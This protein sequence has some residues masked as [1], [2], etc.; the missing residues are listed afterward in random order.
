[1][2]KEITEDNIR[3]QLQSF[4]FGIKILIRMHKRE[5]LHGDFDHMVEAVNLVNNYKDG[6]N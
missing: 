4:F 1:M 3:L 5:P 2:K 6:M